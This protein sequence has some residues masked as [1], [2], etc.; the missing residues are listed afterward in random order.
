MG[1]SVQV[2]PLWP[3]TFP[4]TTHHL[5]PLR[6]GY[7][8]TLVLSPWLGA[9]LPHAFHSWSWVI[10]LW[11]LDVKPHGRVPYAGPGLVIDSRLGNLHL[12]LYPRQLEGRQLC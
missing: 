6:P 9:V 1:N 4:H 7:I 10:M 12:A 2:K 5:Q 3:T 11:G 8:I